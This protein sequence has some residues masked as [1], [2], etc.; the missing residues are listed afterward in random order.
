MHN[1]SLAEYNNFQ[2][3]ET[4]ESFVS[5]GVFLSPKQRCNVFRVT[6]RHNIMQR[7]LIKLFNVAFCLSNTCHVL[8]SFFIMKPAC[9]SKCPRWKIL[10]DVI[11]GE[12]SDY[13]PMVSN[14]RLPIANSHKVWKMKSR[15]GLINMPR[16]IDWFRT[17]ARIN[18]S[19]LRI[20]TLPYP[21]LFHVNE[22]AHFL[23]G[24]YLWSG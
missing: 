17:G 21:N 7:Q 5:K 20:P 6:L 4:G 23:P 11:A 8:G 18:S 19:W 15:R 24:T 9:I 12:T 13:Q 14:R 1:D 10:F 22:W 16:C 2:Q 3:C